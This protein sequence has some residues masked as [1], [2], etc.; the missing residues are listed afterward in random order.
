[1][2][3]ILDVENSN[4]GRALM[5]FLK[6]LSFVKIEEIQKKRRKK[7]EIEGIF[8][9]WSDRDITKKQLREKAW[10]M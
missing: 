1:M 2:R 7:L 10:R 8:G 5:V 6:Q 9:L 3:I 4:E